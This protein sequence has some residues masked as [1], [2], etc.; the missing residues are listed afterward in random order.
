MI[1]HETCLQTRR[2]R[3]ATAGRPPLME[4]RSWTAAQCVVRRSR[5]GQPGPFYQHALPEAA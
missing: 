5:G 1:G 4:A 2:Q 3:G